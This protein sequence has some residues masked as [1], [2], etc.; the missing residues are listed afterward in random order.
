MENTKQKSCEQGKD[1]I[2]TMKPLNPK[3]ICNQ[4]A[5]EMQ[6]KGQIIK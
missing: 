5:Q 3:L 4:E 6:K 1:R 2:V